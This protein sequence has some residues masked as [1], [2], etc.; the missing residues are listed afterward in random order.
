M[1]LRCK[2]P[3]TE[4]GGHG[5]GPY[6]AVR[7]TAAPYTVS[8]TGAA[9]V[10]HPRTIPSSTP[11]VT[12]GG[13]VG[14]SCSTLP[15][16]AL[17][18]PGS[19]LQ[20]L[21][22]WQSLLRRRMRERGPPRVAARRRRALPRQLLGAYQ[23][24]LAHPALA[25]AQGR[26]AAIGDASGFPPCP[27]GCCTGWPSTNRAGHHCDGHPPAMHLYTLYRRGECCHVGR[28]PQGSGCLA[29]PLV[30]P[31]LHAARAPRVPSA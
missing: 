4:V 18:R 1:L 30:S 21:R 24:R 9:A 3:Y 15:V 17:P 13:R 20:R 31:R 6:V 23:A 22:P 12:G 5:G 10:L 11:R 2:T 19:D 28:H 29:M 25:T 8:M 16:R 26:A 27:G 14:Q 7:S